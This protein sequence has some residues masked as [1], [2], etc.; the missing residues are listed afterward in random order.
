[1][2]SYYFI[3][4]LVIRRTTLQSGRASAVDHFPVISFADYKKVCTFVIE[5]I[6]HQ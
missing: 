3:S 5:L 6:N 2:K 4:A 1:M